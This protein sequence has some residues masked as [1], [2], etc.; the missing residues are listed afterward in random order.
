[1]GAE[2]EMKEDMTRIL[3]ASMLEKAFNDGKSSPRRAARNLVDLGVA[4]SKGRF[5]KRF[6]VY[7]QEMLQDQDSAYYDLISD[8]IVHVDRN[9]LVNFGMNLGY[10]GCIKG[11]QKIRSI[12]KEQ[13]F[14]IPWILPMKLNEENIQQMAEEYHR[15][16]RQ[17]KELGIYVYLLQFSGDEPEKLLEFLKENPDCAFIMFLDGQKISQEFMN[18]IKEYKNG[19]ISVPAGK[20][21]VENCR[22]M[23][24]KGLLYAL[25]ASYGDKNGDKIL[26]GS[27]IQEQLCLHSQ[28]LFLLPED[29]CDTE[30]QEKIY[31]YVTKVRMKQRHPVFCMEVKEDFKLIDHIISE[32]SCAVGFD[33]QGDVLVYR[34]DTRMKAREAREK[35][36]EEILR[37]LAPK[38]VL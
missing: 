6:L 26:D 7:A 4:F 3:I 13:G 9:L 10:N 20:D 16:I 24:E 17:G 36:L 18:K 22:E 38:E 28:F 8:V 5:Q 35:S 1:M 14:N 32:D 29:G 12:E 15:R 27:W 23:R 19:M 33:V 30:I 34:N 37:I 31:E 25:Y 11:A 21:S 2:R